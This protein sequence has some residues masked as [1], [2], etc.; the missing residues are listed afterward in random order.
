MGDGS[1]GGGMGA[2]VGELGGLPSSSPS[3]LV[4]N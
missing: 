3:Y 2:A 4:L 1:E